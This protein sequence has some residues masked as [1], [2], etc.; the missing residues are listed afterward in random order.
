M[1]LR[2]YSILKTLSKNIQDSE[3]YWYKN[4]PYK[5]LTTSKIKWPNQF[6][7][8][9]WVD[10]VIYICLYENEDG[11]IWVRQDTIFDHLFT[12]KRPENPYLGPK[13]KSITE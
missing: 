13:V 1:S 12:T 6:G 10:V 11:M 9:E 2:E 3:I 7:E 4:R 5:I 8:D